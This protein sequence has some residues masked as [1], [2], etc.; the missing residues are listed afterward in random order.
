MFVFVDLC[1]CYVFLFVAI[2]PVIVTVICHVPLLVQC[3]TARARCSC[4]CSLLCVLVVVV[5]M[6][7]LFVFV[8]L[9]F[10]LG[11]C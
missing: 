1:C 5:V 4:V 8:L 2:E 6:W 9:V 10:V 11:R 7:S 3:V